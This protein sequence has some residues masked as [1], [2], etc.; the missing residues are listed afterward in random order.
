MRK[1]LCLSSLCFLAALLAC[2]DAPTAPPDS[3]PVVEL[4]PPTGTGP[5]SAVITSAGG[6]LTTTTDGGAVVTLTIPENA[7]LAPTEVTVRPLAAD[8][9]AR[10]GLLLEPASLRLHAPFDLK[11]VLPENVEP[12]D[13]VLLLGEADAAVPLATR[14]DPATRTLSTGALAVFGT[15][16]ESAPSTG[17]LGAVAALSPGDGSNNTVSVARMSC[18]ELTASAQRSFDGF[19]A[20][21]KF[22]RA[23]AAVL[24]I[25]AV[26]QKANCDPLPFLEQARGVACERAQAAFDEVKNEPTA[27]FGEFVRQTNRVISW[28]ELLQLLAADCPAASAWPGVIDQEITEFLAFFQERLDGLAANDF[29]TFLDLKK[30]ALTLIPLRLNAIL[31]G[32]LEAGDMVL[33]DAF[34]PAL[35]R[36]RNIGYTLCRDEGWHYPLSRL[37]S[38][39]FFAGR[40]IIGVDAPRERDVPMTDMT[41]GFSD[42]EIFADIQHCGTRLDVKSIVASGGTLAGDV[43][44][45]KGTP[46]SHVPELTLETPTRGSIR[47]AG[48]LRAMTCWNSVQADTAIEVTLNG[49]LVRTL[50]RADDAYIGDDG[51]LLEIGELSDSAGITPQEGVSHDLVF[52]RLRTDCPESLWG[53]PEYEL[54]TITLDWVNPTLSVE[55]D[56]PETV[57]PGAQ[58]EAAVRVAVIDQLGKTAYFPDV[59]VA[60]TVTGGSTSV[61][62]GKTDSSGYFRT[63]ISAAAEGAEPVRIVANARSFEGATA[64][65]THTAAITGGMARFVSARATAYALAWVGWRSELSREAQADTVHTPS[66]NISVNATAQHDSAGHANASAT[67]SHNVMLAAD[68]RI[69]SVNG[70][71]QASLRISGTN[72]NPQA[73]PLANGH[74]YFEVIGAPVTIHFSGTIGGQVSGGSIRLGLMNPDEPSRA[75]T[76]LIENFHPHTAV[77]DRTVT[78][79]PGL[80]FFGGTVAVTDGCRDCILENEGKTTWKMIVQ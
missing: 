63:S 61:L 77:L 7:V 28:A 21:Q 22:E 70:D 27:D 68:D 18:S 15:T 3:P 40:D 12:V 53:E 66:A 46:G 9:S 65:A 4:P 80:Y 6:T 10:V 30:E 26:L 20:D 58:H 72:G 36:M 5:V 79:E 41:A 76:W 47:L 49:K 33:E 14:F 69:V 42:Q 73:D 13:P 24:S 38:T 32:L 67:I 17:S 2:D 59:D 50:S 57:V 55:I 56:Y 48:D 78:L 45:T 54:L 52:T 11:I 74:V 60:L 39:G 1:F 75:I 8:S 37:T 25:G 71:A 31:L 16:R 23:M 29:Q 34:R 44:G 51:L 43:V 35:D 64:E 19:V 62:S